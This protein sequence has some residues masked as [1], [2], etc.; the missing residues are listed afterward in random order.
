MKVRRI[1]KLM[2]I[3]IMFV[4]MGLYTL[5]RKRILSNN[6]RFTI[7]ITE[8]VY[9]TTMGGK[10]VNF[11]YLVSQKGYTGSENYLNDSIIDDCRCRY[12]V[13]FNYKNPGY[14]R[15]LQNKPVPDSI[16]S[17]PSDGWSKIPGE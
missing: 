10:K 15:L 2:F 1:H 4:L 13:E 16:K 6:A 8:D 5:W 12:Y 11:V 14:G 17:A 9:W 3:A 7:G